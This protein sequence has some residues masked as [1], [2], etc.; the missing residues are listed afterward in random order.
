[1]RAW[2]AYDWANSAWAMTVAVAVLPVYFAGTVVPKGGVELLGLRLDATVLWGYVNSAATL[3]VFLTAPVLGAVAD[4]LGVRRALL[5]AFGLAGGLLT[6]LLAACGPGDVAGTLWLYALSQFAFVSANVFYDSF[7]PHL[8][9]EEELDRLSARGF[10]VGYVGGSLHFVL[11]LVLM[12]THARW[13]LTAEA[14]ARIALGSAGLW[15]AGFGTIAFLGLKE[16]PREGGRPGLLRAVRDGVV[17]TLA[18]TRRV[19]RV[20]PVLLFLL[21]FVLYNDGVQTVVKMASLYGTEEV[22]VGL[23]TMMGTLLGIQLLAMVGALLFARLAGA[24]GT[25]RA[26]QLAVALWLGAVGWAYLLTTPAGFVVLAAIAGLV[27]G[28]VQALSRSLFAAMIPREASAE[29]FGFF[30]VFNKLAGVLG[31]FLFATVRQ[32]TGT[33]R[34]AILSVAVLFVAGLALLFRVDEAEARRRRAELR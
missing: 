3:A 19:A 11:A 27:L 20:K 34:L 17:D 5:T 14:A 25:K 6:M 2:L 8:A 33:S 29:L 22:G 32:A 12:A 7:L 21:A 13:G 16:P 23:P 31:T 10:A 1:M 30:S 28:A 9:S 24:W 18:T 4:R 15:W 26:L